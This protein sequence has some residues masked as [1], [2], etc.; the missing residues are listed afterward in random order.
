MSW[1]TVRMT[2]HNRSQ[3]IAQTELYLNLYLSVTVTMTLHIADDCDLRWEAQTQVWVGK[4]WRWNMIFRRRHHL[5]SWS[6]ELTSTIHRTQR[7][8]EAK[9]AWHSFLNLIAFINQSHL[10]VLM[11]RGVSEA[12]HIPVQN[13]KPDVSIRKVQYFEHLM[14]MIISIYFFTPMPVFTHLHHWTVALQNWYVCASDSSLK[15]DWIQKQ[16]Q[17]ILFQ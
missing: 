14:M 1:L 12:T 15:S 6:A 10:R 16:K 8:T 5:Y 3:G 17:M 4:S 7:I 2:F 13:P 9:W 11:M